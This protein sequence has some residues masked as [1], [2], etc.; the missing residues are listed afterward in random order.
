MTVEIN[1]TTVREIN[2][3]PNSSLIEKLEYCK[4]DRRL[5]VLYKSGKRKGTVRTYHDISF[6]QFMDLL[7]AESLGKAVI[8]LAKSTKKSIS[9]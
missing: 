2:I 3:T 4:S 6:S 5:D 1:T 8:K 7:S 9:D